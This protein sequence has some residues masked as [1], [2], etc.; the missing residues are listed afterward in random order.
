MTVNMNTE[1][2]EELKKVA[3][4]RAPTGCLISKHPDGTWKTSQ[5]KEY[6]KAMSAGIAAAMLRAVCKHR[7]ILTQVDPDEAIA[8][9]VP[10][11]FCVYRHL[12]H[13]A[14]IL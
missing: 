2:N 10:F 1:L 13:F 7:S 3:R 11:S 14:L 5:A 6:P 4:P 12:K 8:F 9:V